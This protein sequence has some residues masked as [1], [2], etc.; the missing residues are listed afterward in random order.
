VQ[1]LHAP[2]AMQF[3]GAAGHEL[4]SHRSDGA[5]GALQRVRAIAARIEAGQARDLRGEVG[6]ERE[7]GQ[8]RG[9]MTHKTENPELDSLPVTDAHGGRGVAVDNLHFTS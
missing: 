2:V 4:C 1:E 6:R 5:I 3:A 7:A 9:D 8:N